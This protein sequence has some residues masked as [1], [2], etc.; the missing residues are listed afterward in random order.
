MAKVDD[1]N[2]NGFLRIDQNI[3]KVNIFVN[4]Y[5]SEREQRQQ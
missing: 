3:I 2:K 5:D 4:L 1:I